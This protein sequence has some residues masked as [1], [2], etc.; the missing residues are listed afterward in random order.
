MVMPTHRGQERGC[1]QQV[2]ASAERQ[3]RLGATALHGHTQRMWLRV[4]IR[5][6]PRSPAPWDGLILGLKAAASPSLI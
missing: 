3:F 5:D 4:K 1:W 2:V 6:D